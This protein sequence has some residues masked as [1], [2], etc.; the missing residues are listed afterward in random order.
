M[1]TSWWVPARDPLLTP[2]SGR[3]S[4]QGHL[5]LR[6][7]RRPEEQLVTG[8]TDSWP[9]GGFHQ[10]TSS[11]DQACDGTAPKGSGMP[12]DRRWCSPSPWPRTPLLQP[13][14][15]AR[16]PRS[17]TPRSLLARHG[18]LELRCRSPYSLYQWSSCQKSPKR[19]SPSPRMS[20]SRRSPQMQDH[21]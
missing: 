11:D 4:Q 17:L 13:R 14:S 1:A 5:C 7:A 2:R 3:G 10:D 21:S 18:T 19:R 8:T 15:L 6:W 12:P 20:P 9:H 16:R